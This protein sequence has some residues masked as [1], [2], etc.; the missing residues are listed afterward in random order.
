MLKNVRDSIS[1]IYEPYENF[2]SYDAIST[3]TRKNFEIVSNCSH[4]LPHLPIPYDTN[5]QITELLHV[6]FAQ[7]RILKFD[8]LHFAMPYTRSVHFVILCPLLWSIIAPR[9]VF[10]A[11]VRLWQRF[12]ETWPW[13]ANKRRRKNI[14]YYYRSSDILFFYK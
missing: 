5:K 2:Q 12:L 8:R 1:M 3:S 10:L 13:N 11:T 14:R 7:K 6:S 4:Y 9:R